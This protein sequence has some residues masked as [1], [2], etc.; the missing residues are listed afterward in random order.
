[1]TQYSSF[2]GNLGAVSQH[3]TPA[4]DTTYDLGHSAAKFRHLYLSGNSLYLGGAV[5]NSSG[6]SV[7]LPSGTTVGGSPITTV[8]SSG[9]VSE[10]TAIAYAVALG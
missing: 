5:I 9:G 2:K 8:A 3:I 7:A 1:M 6:S 10:A 4:A